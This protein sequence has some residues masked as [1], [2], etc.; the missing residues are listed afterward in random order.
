[1]VPCIPSWNSEPSRTFPTEPV[2]NGR[3]LLGSEWSYLPYIWN[4]PQFSMAI[5][6]KSV[7]R[8]TL[9]SVRN[10]FDSSRV[11]QLLCF[12]HAFIQ[13]GCFLMVI[14][15]NNVGWY[16]GKPFPSA[17]VN[18]LLI[19]PFFSSFCESDDFTEYFPWVRLWL[20]GESWTNS[21]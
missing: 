5:A 9:G 7:G 16:T 17:S 19:S 13:E 2:P 14:T 11:C 18:S 15:D 6:S 8:M 20:S 4:V 21:K 1:M 3:Y 12:D 10:T